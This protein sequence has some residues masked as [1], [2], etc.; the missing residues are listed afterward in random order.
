LRVAGAARWDHAAFLEFDSWTLVSF[1]CSQNKPD[2]PLKLLRTVAPQERADSSERNVMSVIKSLVPAGIASIMLALGGCGSGSGDN[3][4]ATPSSGTAAP[5][6]GLQPTLAS[7][8]DLVFTP[9]CI[10]C[11]SGANAPQ[12]LQ[13]TAGNSAANLINV[14]AP[15]DPTQIR[16]I[17]GNPDGSLLIQKLEGTATLGARMPL[18]Q[19]PL[20]PSTIAVIRQWITNGAPT[21]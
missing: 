16:V 10:G 2:N 19:P 18:G 20:D 6:P 15:R 12:G 11:H 7:I 21:T 8:Q 3:M 4:S 14:P 13:L 9:T 1:G 17:P 5:I